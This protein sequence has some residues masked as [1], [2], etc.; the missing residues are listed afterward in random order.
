MKGCF[1]LVSAYKYRCYQLGM[2]GSAGGYIA[3]LWGSEVW[4]GVV[5]GERKR[6]SRPGVMPLLGLRGWCLG[7]CTFIGE[8]KT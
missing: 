3:C 4:G 2:P 6:A 5:E 8:F 7:F 1:L